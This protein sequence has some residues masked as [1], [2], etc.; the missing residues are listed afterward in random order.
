MK[1][2]MDAKFTFTV[3]TFKT[4]SK[5][6]AYFG[7]RADSDGV[8][9]RLC[10]GYVDPLLPILVTRWIWFTIFSVCTQMKC[11]RTS[12]KTNNSDITFSNTS[13]QAS[14]DASEPKQIALSAALKRPAPLPSN[15]PRYSSLLRAI[16]N[17]VFQTLQSLSIVDEPSFC[18]LL[19]LLSLNFSYHIVH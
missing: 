10:V 18:S 13:E 16:M 12:G 4:K 15:R 14:E 6:W 17:F 1:W 3:P 8:I 2:E 9:W 11:L 7:F 19:Q 5:N